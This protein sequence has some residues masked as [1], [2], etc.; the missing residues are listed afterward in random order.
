MSFSGGGACYGG[1]VAVA[2]TFRGGGRGRDD[3]WGAGCLVD[4]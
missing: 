1:E 4:L 2:V 3:P